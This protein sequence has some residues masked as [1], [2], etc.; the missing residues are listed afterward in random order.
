MSAQPAQP[1]Q[2]FKIS[3]LTFSVYLPSFVFAIGQGAVLPIVP[4]FAK[5]LGASVAV[6]GLI[7]ALRGI[8]TLLMD[9]PGGIFVSRFGDKGAMVAGTAIAAVVAIGASF[10]STPLMLA[11]L[12]LVMGG[13]WSFWQLARISYVTEVTPIDQRGRVISLLGGTNRFGTVVGP[14][15]GG[16]V[17]STFGLE[18]AFYVQALMGLIAAGLMLISVKDTAA[19]DDTSH[20]SIGA[21]M[22]RTLQD[23][24]QV[25]ATTLVPMLAL[26]VLRQ[27]RQVFLPLWGDEIGL[28]VAAI[29]IVY[30]VSYFLDAALFYPVGL[31]MDRY[32]RKWA[33][34]PCLLALGIGL[35]LLPLTS[36]MVGFVLVA[37]F[38]GIG[39]GFGSGIMMTLGADFSPTQGRGEF[40]GVWRLL[41]DIGSAGGP[42]AI[43]AIIGAASLAAAAVATGGFGVLGAL[44]MFLFV[45]ETLRRSRVVAESTSAPGIDPVGPRPGHR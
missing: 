43:S 35:I 1:E 6:A 25:F 13:S 28:D 11:V 40:L 26:A 19:Q 9:V 22:V 37:L 16:T 45:P 39:N 14:I 23:H 33:G 21:A 32:G 12:M 27:G 41:G 20:H 38:T 31:I 36:E 44:V 3:S 10:I 34:V 18:W 4:L 7:V 24:R 30:G 42:V 2:P 15:L 17:G 29:G 5:E 8:G